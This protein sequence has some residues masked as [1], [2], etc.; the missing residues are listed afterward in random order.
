MVKTQFLLLLPVILHQ[1]KSFPPADDLVSA[2][3]NID[4]ELLKERSRRDLRQIGKVHRLQEIL[5]TVYP[6]DASWQPA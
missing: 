5:P 3:K 1:M 6:Q 4:W 2:V